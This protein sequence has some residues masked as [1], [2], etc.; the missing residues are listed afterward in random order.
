MCPKYRKGF[1]VTQWNP[2]EDLAMDFQILKKISKAKK[3]TQLFLWM[4]YL[5]ARIWTGQCPSSGS[6]K[7]AEDFKGYFYFILFSAND[8]N[9]SIG[10]KEQPCVWLCNNG[11]ITLVRAEA[12]RKDLCGIQ[13]KD[14]CQLP[15]RTDSFNWI[16]HSHV[17]L[18]RASPSKTV[19]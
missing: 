13:R 4:D 12:A 3:L 10:G 9:K 6:H 5:T 11:L 1:V 8:H 19:E 14:V 16:A 7:C 18:S 17:L 2:D 15:T